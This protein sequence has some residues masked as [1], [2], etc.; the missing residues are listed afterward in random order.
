ME[1]PNN[2]RLITENIKKSQNELKK[3]G[4]GF[5]FLALTSLILLTGIDLYR[6]YQKKVEIENKNKVLNSQVKYW[7]DLVSKDKGYRDG[8]FMLSVLEYQL[9]DLSKAKEYLEKAIEIDPNFMPASDLQKV[10]DRE[11]K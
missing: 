10:L 4:I 7:Q 3:V 6:S 2:F 9:K 8:Y 5:V 1:F 11:L